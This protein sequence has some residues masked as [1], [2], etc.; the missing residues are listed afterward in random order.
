MLRAPRNSRYIYDVSDRPFSAP[1]PRVFFRTPL[2]SSS[3]FLF[4]PLLFY[5]AI[6]RT[7]VCRSISGS[8]ME[9]FLRVRTDS[10]LRSSCFRPLCRSMDR[11]IETTTG[12]CVSLGKRRKVQTTSLLERK[13]RF[14]GTNYTAWEPTAR[15]IAR[16][17]QVRLITR[18]LANV[19]TRYARTSQLYPLV[20][21]IS[22]EATHT[23][24][25]LMQR[26]SLGQNE[27]R[28]RSKRARRRYFISEDRDHRR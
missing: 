6:H 13:G 14:V 7:T 3:H 17:P 10:R 24:A 28:G 2:L 15:R 23:L 18:V 19:E 12:N 21:A 27:A 4:L 8:T 5:S 9:F 20:R 16:T 26:S 11:P 22:S 1:L 25:Y